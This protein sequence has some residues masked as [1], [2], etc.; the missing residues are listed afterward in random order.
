MNRI[1]AWGTIPLALALIAVFLY[2]D[3]PPAAQASHLCGNTGS[4]QGAFDLETYE[5]ADWRTTYSQAF[6]LAGF[7]RLFPDVSGGFALPSLET[8]DRSAGSS[9]L[10]DP[11][12]PPTLLK[13]IAWIESNWSQADLSVPYGAVGPV[14]VSHD[15]GYGLMQITTGMQNVSGVPTI[16]QAMIGGHYAFNIARGARILADKWNAA[17][18]YRPIAGNRDPLVIENWYY[19]VWSYNGFT[20]KN[21][22]LNSAYSLPRPA[23]RC[24]GTQSRSNYPYQELV[25]GCIANPPVVGGQ[26]LWN[27]LVVP[28]P[29]LSDPAF[30]LGA[31]DACSI[32]RAC[33]AMDLT[34]PNPSHL[35]SDVGA[36]S[37]GD[38]RIDV[39]A[40]A[41]D[42]GLWHRY[43][44]DEGWSGWESLGG[45]LN[46]GPDVSS[47]A[48]GRLD[49]FALDTA[50]KL[51][52][53]W[54]VRGQGWSGWE[55]LGAPTGLT[56]V[57][58]PSAVSWGEGRIDVFGQ[59]SDDGLWHRSYV[60]DQGWSG[61]ENLGGVL[62]SGSDVSS[63]AEGRLDVFAL[64]MDNK[65]RHKW[66]V[67]GQGWSGWENLGAPSGLTLASDPGA[68]SWGEGRID[69]FARASDDG[70]WHRWYVRGEG[71]SGW[72]PLGGV[73]NSGPDV[74]SWAEG[75]LDVFALGTD[76]KLRHKWY[77]RG[78]GWFP[79]GL[80][81]NLV[82]P[83]GLILTSDPGA[84]SWG[85][86]RP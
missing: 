15:C 41:S 55:N 65:L 67:R 83:S 46:S 75:R 82:A 42:G 6:A 61:W 9:Q 50:Y 72:E 54:Y 76:D 21:H 31:W 70:L 14:L 86:G 37:W 60:R 5:A 13:A 17:P 53:K 19:A 36:V 81:E 27:P 28:L 48:E 18:E 71:W 51:R 85:E 43:V 3:N 64:G 68:V 63:W 38:G 1:G 74:S 10:R 20:F 79:Q 12:I 56:L 30:S 32:N 39:F 58:A 78:Q 47:W 25:F 57:S 49:V 4:L 34:I 26:A 2:A 69:V 8:G 16:G 23:Y 80:W 62:N 22:P 29:N 59:A 52:H 35:T 24:D 84:V 44:Q 73:L 11:Y 66:Y 77:I 45:V 33:A 40:R 7:N